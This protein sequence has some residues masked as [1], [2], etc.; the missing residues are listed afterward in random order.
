MAKDILTLG[1]TEI[2]KHKFYRD[3]LFFEKEFFFF[4]FFFFGERKSISI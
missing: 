4:F 3:R 1:D 2:E